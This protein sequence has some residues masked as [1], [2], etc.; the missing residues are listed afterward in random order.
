MSVF[1]FA[2][3]CCWF[4]GSVLT[5]SVRFR[6]ASILMCDTKAWNIVSVNIFRYMLEYASVLTDS[7]ITMGYIFQQ[8]SMFNSPNSGWNTAT[9]ICMLFLFYLAS[10]INSDVS[11]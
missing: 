10:V 9:T 6:Q 3:S 1:K 2:I 11:G 5:L 8:A 7:V 4:V